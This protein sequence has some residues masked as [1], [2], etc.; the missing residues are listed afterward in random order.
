MPN[1]RPMNLLLLACYFKGERFMT[2]AHARG[3]RVHLLTQERLRDKAWPHE[4]LDGFFAQMNEAPLRSTINTVTYMMRTIRFD[5]VVGLDD[6]DVETAASLREHLRLPGMGESVARFF[7]DKL[8]C[9]IKCRELGIP[10]PEFTGVF[11]NDEV[12]EFI[13]RVPGPWMLKPRSEAS[14]TGIHKVESADELWRLLDSKGDQRSYMLLEKYLP[15]DVYHADSLTSEGKVVFAEVHRCLTPPFNVAH[16]GGIFASVTVPRESEDARQLRALNEKALVGLGM[17]RGASHVEFIKGREDGRFYLLETAARVG[18][19]HIAEQVEASTGL[20][21][22]EQW[23]NLEIDGEGYQVPARREEYGGLL[24]TLTKQERPDLSCFDGPE[25][26][27]RAPEAWHAGIVLRAPTYERLMELVEAHSARL[28]AEF[29]STLP[30][31]TRA[32]H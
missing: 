26:F 17:K 10:V 13:A 2:Q 31:P 21:L 29:S 19:A 3:A 20:N 4:S 30:A 14:A 1:D 9:R 5:R 16:G 32:T 15:G 7:R 28:R 24:V 18:G 8:A 27:Y 23:A 11:N 22:W 25:L 12:A 6:F